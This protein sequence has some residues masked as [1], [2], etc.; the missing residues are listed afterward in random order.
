MLPVVAIVGRPNVGKSTLFNRLIGERLSITDDQPGV[1]RDRIYAKGEWLGKEFNLIDTGGIDIKDA[2]FLLEIRQ[3]AELA[4]EEA[5][6]IV[7]LTDGRS[8]VTEED[9][10][11]AR[12]LY[13]S[14]KP[15]ILAINKI[16]G[17]HL[18]DNKYDFYSLGLGEPIA[19]SSLHGIGIGDLLD[20]IISNFPEKIDSLPKESIKFSVIGRPNVGKSS[21]TNALLGEERVIVSNIEGTTRDAID[22]MFKKDGKDYA[23]IDTAGIRKRGK[24]I[25]NAEKY[26]VLRALQAID[27]SD[28][29]LILID[30]EQGIREQDK[31]IAGY[32]KESNKGIII[33]INKWDLVDKHDKIMKEWEQELRSHFK[34]ITY[35]PIV[36][37]SALTKKR[38]HTLFESIDEVYENYQKRFKTHIINDIIVDALQ[39]NPTPQFNGG[40]LKVYY[41]TQATSSP[42]TFI[43]F[44]N[45]PEYA[46]FSYIRYL[47]NCLRGAFNFS[48]TPI[49]FILRKRD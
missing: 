48:G 19:I 45:D 8:T 33:V 3:Q 36:Y 39:M 25:E 23:V 30:G 32:A 12:I 27:R 28:I 46:H 13:K 34:F 37:L 38:I 6:V 10:I 22:T 49:K 42:P 1:T 21:L 5:D 15:I 14:D 2:P 4:I 18:L 24:V 41:S 11:V 9:E 35:A 43:L 20:N 26:S 31:R 40:R 17:E 16:D 7:F 47:E 29:C 44:V